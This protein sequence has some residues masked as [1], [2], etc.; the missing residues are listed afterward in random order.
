MY[1]ELDPFVVHSDP[2]RKGGMYRFAGVRDLRD[3]DLVAPVLESLDQGIDDSEG[4]IERS[5]ADLDIQNI[6]GSWQADRRYETLDAGSQLTV[7]PIDVGP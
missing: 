7:A 6:Y 2:R 3:L 1:C 4:S 5:F